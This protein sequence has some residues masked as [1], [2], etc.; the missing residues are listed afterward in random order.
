M[1][2]A[3]RREQHSA[4]GMAQK[5]ARGGSPKGEESGFQILRF[6]QDD[7]GSGVNEQEST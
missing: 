1:G 2:E 6:A 4:E 7:V 5:K 3:Q